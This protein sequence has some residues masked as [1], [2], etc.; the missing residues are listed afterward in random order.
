MGKITKLLLLISLI[1]SFSACVTKAFLSADNILYY[2]GK[3]SAEANNN[4]MNLYERACIKP[5][6][7]RIKSSGGDVFLGLDLGDWVFKNKLNIEVIDYCLSS[8]ANYVFTAGEAKLLNPNSALVWHGG[9]LQ[10][11]LL[12]ESNKEFILGWR[13]REKLFFKKIG[14]EQK[15][16]IYGQELPYKQNCSDCIG[17]DYSIDD[18]K[19]MGLKNIIELKTDWNWRRYHKGLRA[20]RVN[21][22]LVSYY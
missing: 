8:C 10:A 12:N 13:E 6:L 4:L 19:K 11:D 20:F 7:L 1:I 21:L 18:M 3:L 17:F 15:I 16:T 2:K 22:D 9:S 5:R 14:V